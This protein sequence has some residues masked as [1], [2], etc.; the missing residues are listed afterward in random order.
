MLGAGTLVKGSHGVF[1]F[2]GAY[3]PL[4]VCALVVMAAHRLHAFV[5]PAHAEH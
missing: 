1:A 4:V 5:L 3:L 2:L